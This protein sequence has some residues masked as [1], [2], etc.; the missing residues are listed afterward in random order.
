ML[1]EKLQMSPEAYEAKLKA[2][3]QTLEGREIPSAVPMAPPIGYKKQPSMVEH[4]RNMVRSEMVRQAAEAKGFETFEE[5]DDFDVADDL[6]PLSG[7]ENDPQF[8]PP[9]PP[10]ES[11][12]VPSPSG[13]GEGAG[14]ESASS[15]VEPPPEA[16]AEEG[17]TPAAPP[18]KPLAAPPGPRKPPPGP[19]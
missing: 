7:Y 17:K 15:P 2:K 18:V 1:R 16:K 13:G 6:E 11:T 5:A 8:E 19:I 10:E 9:V 12:G 4:I 14:G 3:D